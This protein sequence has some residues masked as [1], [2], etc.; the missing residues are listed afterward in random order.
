MK[1]KSSPVLRG[2]GHAYMTFA[3]GGGGVPKKWMKNLGCVNL[4]RGMR[5]R[6][7]KSE[8]FVD[9][10]RGENRRRTVVLLG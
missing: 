4:A 1:N 7:K 2:G 6:G 8:S 5:E 10:I 3:V 9:V